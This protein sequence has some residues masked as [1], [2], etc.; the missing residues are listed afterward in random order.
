M[1]YYPSRGEIQEC[2]QHSHMKCYYFL[3]LEMHKTAFPLLFP[4]LALKP[5]LYNSS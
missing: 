1:S 3:Q 2:T 5:A 4:A